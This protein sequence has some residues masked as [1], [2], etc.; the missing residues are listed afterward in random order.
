MHRY[1]IL[2]IFLVRNVYYVLDLKF[3]LPLNIGTN[4]QTSSGPSLEYC[5]TVISRKNN[6]KQIVNNKIANAITN[7]LPPFLKLRNLNY[8]TYK[9]KIQ[10]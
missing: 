4:F 9:Y 8:E 2:I 10:S 7:A 6:G 1:L 3:L 5:A